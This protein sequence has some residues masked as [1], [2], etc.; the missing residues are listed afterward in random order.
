MGKVIGAWKGAADQG[1][2]DAKCNLGV[3]YSE[4]RGA[5]QSDK[6]AAVWFGKAADQGYADA[7]YCMG[8]M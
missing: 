5:P 2:A 6:E 7:Q 4:G 1:H 8:R 3:M